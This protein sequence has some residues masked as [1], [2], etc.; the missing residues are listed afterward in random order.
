[1][2]GNALASVLQDL[3]GFHLQPGGSESQSFEIRSST[4]T[5]PQTE[6]PLNCAFRDSI[7]IVT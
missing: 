6:S 3:S 1:M 4:T 2:I 5:C 7:I